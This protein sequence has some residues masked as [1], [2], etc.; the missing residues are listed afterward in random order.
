MSF[1]C[2]M[3]SGALKAYDHRK[4]EHG[5]ISS[6]CRRVV[7]NDGTRVLIRARKLVEEFDLEVRSREAN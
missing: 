6:R 5:D 4:A 3:N 2:S 1:S 7:R